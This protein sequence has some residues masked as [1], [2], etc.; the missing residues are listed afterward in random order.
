MTLHLYGEGMGEFKAECR[1][2]GQDDL[3]LPGVGRSRGS[4]T[5][6]QCCPNEG[7]FAPAGKTPDQGSAACSTADEGRGTF[8]F[9]LEVAADD[10][11]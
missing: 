8:P 5:G 4:R 2:S 9:A 10:D 1:F 11:G 7:S 6:T 3:L